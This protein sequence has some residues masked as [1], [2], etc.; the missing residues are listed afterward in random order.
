MCIPYLWTQTC[1]SR[2]VIHH[3]MNAIEW[4]RGTEVPHVA[5]LLGMCSVTHSTSLRL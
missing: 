2:T 5:A 1:I 4:S 3:G